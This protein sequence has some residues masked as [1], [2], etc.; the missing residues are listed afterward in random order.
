VMMELHAPVGGYVMR[1]MK[2]CKT[3][4]QQPGLHLDG[5]MK[6]WGGMLGIVTLTTELRRTD[7]D[8]MTVVWKN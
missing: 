8:Q 7:E 6:I 3:G 1:V 5:R 2:I 4:L